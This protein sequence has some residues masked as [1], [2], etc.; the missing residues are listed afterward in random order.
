MAGGPLGFFFFNKTKKPAVQP[1]DPT[2]GRGGG[3]ARTPAGRRGIA[4]PSFCVRDIRYA[5]QLVCHV[6]LNGLKATRQ[7]EF[8]SLGQFRHV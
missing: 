4:S 8:Q 6:G 7:G 1:S 5:A 2:A 3:R